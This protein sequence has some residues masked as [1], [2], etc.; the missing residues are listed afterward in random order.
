VVNLVK[1]MLDC[2]PTALVLQIEDIA[3]SSPRREWKWNATVQEHA[4]HVMDAVA[5]MPS[6]GTSIVHTG[7]GTVI[8][9]GCWAPG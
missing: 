3:T 8:A 6:N 2:Q 4:I 9:K 5:R 1:M 7:P